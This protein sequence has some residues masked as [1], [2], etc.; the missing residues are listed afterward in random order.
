MYLVQ[1]LPYISI[2]PPSRSSRRNK[3]C[4]HVKYSAFW[5]LKDIAAQR[6]VSKVSV[7]V[8]NGMR[9]MAVENPW[10]V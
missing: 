1:R 7:G 6:R 4:A 2:S 3:T 9:F 5:N 10:W 8:A